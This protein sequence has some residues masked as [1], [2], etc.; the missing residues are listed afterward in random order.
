MK[1]DNMLQLFSEIKA[2]KPLI[3]HITNSVTMNDCANV[4]LAVGASPVMASAIEEAADMAKLAD[5][6]VLN[7]GT[8]TEQAFTAMIA[9]GKAANAKGI[10]V[11]LDPVGAGATAFRTEKAGILL[12]EVDISIIRGNASEIS[13][14]IGGE[15]NTKGVDAGEVS[16]SIRELA[17][18]AA[19]KL[20]AVIVISGAKD[21]VC[22]G[23]NIT[24]ISN[25]DIWLTNVTGTGCMATSIIAS[26]AAVADDHYSAAIAGISIMSLAGELAR[27]KVREEEGIGT[28]RMKLMDEIF[29]MNAES[30]EKG[31]K[32]ETDRL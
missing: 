29:L 17:Q 15:M 32:L 7:L 19:D 31:V 20:Q 11:V 27:K 2:K 16:L 14:L 26:M 18:V 12:E 28:F 30:W 24:E 6:L 1:I 8:I 25:G 10:P 3:H 23:V 21:T 13:A 5:S 9:A 22:G 4:T